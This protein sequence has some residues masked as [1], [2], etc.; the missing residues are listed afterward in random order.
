MKEMGRDITKSLE[1]PRSPNW[2]Q[3]E[4]AVWAESREE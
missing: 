2:T 1:T 3:V 4:I